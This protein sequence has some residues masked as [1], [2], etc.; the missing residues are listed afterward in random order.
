MTPKDIKRRAEAA[1]LRAQGIHQVK[2]VKKVKEPVETL[3]SV[4]GI[5][6]IA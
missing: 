4:W 2:W 3:E 1:E 6:R 5:R